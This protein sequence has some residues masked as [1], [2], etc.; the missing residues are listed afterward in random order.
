MVQVPV[1]QP[2][3]P[4]CVII[5]GIHRTGN[6]FTADTA[7]GMGEV[8]HKISQFLHVSTFDILVTVDHEDPVMGSLA[9]GKISGGAKI[10]APF[11]GEDFIGK[12]AC[13][14][15]GIV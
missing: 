14:F 11:K 1:K 15:P 4:V 5:K 9:D 3:C 2:F 8:F 7:C 12:T 10:V 13:N 6:I